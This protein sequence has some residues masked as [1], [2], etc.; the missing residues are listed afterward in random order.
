M[1]TFEKQFGVL[2]TKNFVIWTD[3]LATN[4]MMH[5]TKTQFILFLFKTGIMS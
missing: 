1:W 3:Y 4:M 2:V 5:P